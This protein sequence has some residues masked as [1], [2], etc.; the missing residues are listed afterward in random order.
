L[1]GSDW[2]RYGLLVTCFIFVWMLPCANEWTIIICQYKIVKLLFYIRVILLKVSVES[3]MITSLYKIIYY[4][5][6][7][8]RF[9]MVL[10]D[11]RYHVLIVCL[12][13]FANKI[14]FIITHLSLLCELS[15]IDN[16]AERNVWLF[17]MTQ[18]YIL[19][20]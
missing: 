5:K 3:N 17:S 8:I 4:I 19:F 18:A 1:L 11:L 12:F 9:V 2:L 13:C 16:V 10:F 14:F 6:I 15:M 20:Q 7:S